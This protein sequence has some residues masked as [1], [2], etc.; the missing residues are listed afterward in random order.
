MRRHHARWPQLADKVIAL[1]QVCT[2]L[3]NAQLIPGFGR[4][5]FWPADAC[6]SPVLAEGV[7]NGCTT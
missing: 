4:T 7:T 6:K 1:T 3:Y 5:S 2:A